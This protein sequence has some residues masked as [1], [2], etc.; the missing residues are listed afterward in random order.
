MKKNYI[1][2]SAPYTSKFH[3]TMFVWINIYI[4]T[5]LQEKDCTMLKS[6]LVRLALH[7]RQCVV[8][9]VDLGILGKRYMSFARKGAEGAMYDYK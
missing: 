6:Q 1:H 8:S 5:Y 2:M 7:F 4:V 3:Y 9:L